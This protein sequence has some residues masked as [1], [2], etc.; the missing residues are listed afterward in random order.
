MTPTQ[1]TALR[2]KCFLDPTAAAFF[3][4]RD[5]GGLRA[6]IN[7]IASPAYTVY[8]NS[9]PADD[10]NDA[11]VW[12]NLTPTDSPSTL[13]TYTNQ[14]LVCQ[15]KQMNLQIQLQGRQAI[16]TGKSSIRG[17]FQD[18]LTNVPSG[19]GGVLQGAGWAAVK[20]VMSRL[21]TVAEKMLA[22]GSGTAASPS[23]LDLDGLVSE[24]D[25]GTIM[26]HDNG[27][28]WTAGG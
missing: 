28:V 19:I 23:A 17:A 7:A 6:Y 21:A 3:P 18:A 2:A 27:V 10:I 8:S 15:T 14:V 12:A 1:I 13:V 11:V 24:Q 5:S 20:T 9:T 25:T 22:T 4:L 16:N 26:F